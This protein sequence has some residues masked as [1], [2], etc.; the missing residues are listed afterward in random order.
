MSLQLK[1]EEKGHRVGNFHNY[2]TFNP[3]S[4]RISILHNL[5]IIQYLHKHLIIRDGTVATTTTTSCFED[6][7]RT[8]KRLK[9]TDSKK[10]QG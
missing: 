10:N 9:V 8:S 3:T 5:N 6:E 7:E 2:Y 1:D 4:N